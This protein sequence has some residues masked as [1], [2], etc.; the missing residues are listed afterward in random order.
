MKTR[1][2]APLVSALLRAGRELPPPPPQAF[3]RTLAHSRL[4]LGTAAALG[5][6]LT[7]AETVA[8][9]AA[10]HT[11]AATGQFAP[12]AGGGAVSTASG[13]LAAGA[14]GAS[15]LSISLLKPVGVGV[16]IGALSLGAVEVERRWST[17]EAPA[18]SSSVP[19]TSTT[20]V[21]SR[22]SSRSRAESAP[23]RA[24]VAAVPGE[25]SAS[26]QSTQ[27]ARKSLLA[28]IRA[29][30]EAR[31]A[32]A[33]GDKVNTRRWLDAYHA[34]FPHGQLAPEAELL[35]RRMVEGQ[36]APPQ[37]SQQ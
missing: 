24:V 2:T 32:F 1:N 21:P 35:E 30:D 10:S 31:S 12:A 7:A 29:L 13:P 34:R 22:P 33:K 16:A 8:K 27:A 15:L 11:A 28:E 17:P 14:K 3:E 5:T 18:H 6:S 23:S 36:A 26:G 37:R 19:A 4:A 25:V 9:A 20:P